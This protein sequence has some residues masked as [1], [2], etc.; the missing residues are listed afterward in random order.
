MSLA[1]RTKR[2]LAS[3][4][5]TVVPAAS[6]GTTDVAPT[7]PLAVMAVIAAVAP[8]PGGP[9]TRYA[10]LEPSAPASVPVAPCRPMAWSWI[11]VLP[12]LSTT[13]TVSV[14]LVTTNQ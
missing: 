8:G 5:L 10:T 3:A 14:A 12:P 7:L 1:Q 11:S 9:L 2:F 4:M 13:M 6:K